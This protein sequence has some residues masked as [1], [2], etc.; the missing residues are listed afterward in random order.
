[1]TAVKWGILSTARINRLFLAGARQAHNVEIFA[2]ASRSAQRAEQYARENQI[3]RAYGSYE[4]LLRDP[5][6]EAVYISLPNSFH[7]DLSIRALE[8]GK[9][10]L[11][12][13]PL[14]RRPREVERAFD[15][16][17]RNQRLL[18][19]AF[20]Y[21]H[22]PQTRRLTKL[23]AEGA[24]GR[25]RV[26]RAAFGFVA[27]DPANVRLSPTLDGGGLMDVGCYCLSAARLI[28]GEPER[29]SAEQ[30]LGGDG[31]D[32]AFAA[33]MRHR[34]DVLTHFDAGLALA[35]RD[36]L[37]IV[38]DGGSLLLT[39]PWHCRNPGIELTREDGATEW[40]EVEKAD[41]YALEAENFSASIRGEGEPLLGRAD[42]LGQARAI[43]ALY[44]AADEARVMTLTS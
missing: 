7:V 33:V 43:E 44:A 14:S 18:M 38:G 34:D 16:A 11:C 37:E 39:D 27:S 30:L 4:E 13:K 42:A 12:E 6:V 35:S 22:H 32:V 31:V 2:V 24:V 40:I 20:M 15:A 23:I 21:R 36:L 8:A 5:D 10:V 3:A 19:E 25:L 17:E 29:V 9:H 1:M 26:I 41:S 28:A